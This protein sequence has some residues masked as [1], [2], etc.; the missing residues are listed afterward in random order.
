MFYQN[1]LHEKNCGMLH[2]HSENDPN[3]RFSSVM[4][5]LWWQ[6][7][8]IEVTHAH[9]S[10]FLCWIFIIITWIDLATQWYRLSI[11]NVLIKCWRSLTD[12]IIYKRKQTIN[13]RHFSVNIVYFP[14]IDY[15]IIKG[16]FTSHF[17]KDF[18]VKNSFM[19]LHIWFRWCNV[20]SFASF[21]D[22]N[23]G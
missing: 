19:W 10:L 14:R 1:V 22:N 17:Q 3:W 23:Y 2:L 7:W 5:F 20:L 11:S 18:H 16:I 8:Y 9:S 4:C 13:I 21:L 6:K 12:R 15:R